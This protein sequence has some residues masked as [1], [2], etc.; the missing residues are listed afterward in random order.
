MR[1]TVLS[2]LL[3]VVLVIGASI[4]FFNAQPVT[5]NYLFGELQ[6]PL[7]AILIADFLIAVLLTLLV[8]S[9]RVFRSGR[10]IARLRRQLRDTE[11]EL[12]NLRNLPVT[13]ETPHA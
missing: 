13:V 5:L 7:F 4:G 3:V 1:T 8:V 6:L 9:A 12:R 2:L 10:E 11:S